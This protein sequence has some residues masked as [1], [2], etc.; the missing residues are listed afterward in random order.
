MPLPP[1]NEITEQQYNDDYFIGTPTFSLT[2]IEKPDMSPFLIHMTGENEIFS[3]LEG[4][5]TCTE[6][7]GCLLASVPDY[8]NGNR[9]FTVPVVC[10]TESP[11][12][13]IDF[14]RYRRKERWRADQRFG[15]GFSKSALVGLGVRPV[16]YLES[17]LVRRV[18]ALSARINPMVENLDATRPITVNQQCLRDA[19]F[20]L[21]R[22]HPLLFPLE[23]SHR[24]QGFMWER[25][26]RYFSSE[27][28]IF[29]HQDI[30]VICCPEI[31]EARIREILGR[32]ADGVSFVRTW[33]EYSDVTQYLASQQMIWNER[34]AQLAQ[35]N[36]LAAQ[37]EQAERL[38]AERNRTLRS[39]EDYER[40]IQ[41]MQRELEV[42]RESR[43][44]IQQ[45]IQQL[46]QQLEEINQQEQ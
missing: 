17:D 42:A 36:N 18:I 5:E 21:Q 1:P 27:E 41:Q 6:E 35:A 24:F 30:E 44:D 4:G 10:F 15:I 38:I 7:Q 45:D 40:I 32:H 20:I 29:D 9:N 33:H 39:L 43:R 34:Q 16:I 3:I 11:T 19:D 28:L 37:R 12:F 14:F 2:P 23:E 26:W 31:E 46:R 22:I 8:G 13:A 25:E